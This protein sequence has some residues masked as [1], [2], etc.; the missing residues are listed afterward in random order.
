MRRSSK[1]APFLLHPQREG[2]VNSSKDTRVISRKRPRL[3]RSSVVSG[4]AVFRPLRPGE[5]ACVSNLRAGPRTHDSV[6]H[7]LGF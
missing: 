1:A 2:W 6:R 3:S 7:H 4:N 5:R